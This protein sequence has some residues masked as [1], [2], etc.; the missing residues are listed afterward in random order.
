MVT[1]GIRVRENRVKGDLAQFRQYLGTVTR[2]MLKQ[3]ASLTARSALK[4]APP[5]VPTGGKGDTGA[6]GKTGERAIDKDVRAIFAEPGSTLASVFN[7][8]NRRGLFKDF[9]RWRSKPNTAGGSTL[10]SKIYSDDD[11]QRAF[12][13][14][15]N[16]FA[17]KPN[18]SK[19]VV[20]V[21]QMS[22]IHKQQRVKGRV[23][24][25]GRPDKETKRYPY[26]AKA[27]L[28]NKYVKLRSRAIGKLKSGWWEIIDRH[29]RG[30]VI[31][32]RV[33]DSGSKGLPKYITR[34]RGPGSL[35]ETKGGSSLRVRITNQIG[36][37]DGAG[38]RANTFSLVIRDRLAAISKRPYQQYA[39]RIVR[40][41][42]ANLPASS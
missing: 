8:E 29:G 22:T 41:W 16:L 40:N 10:I 33:V 42:N 20:N 13:K 6:A 24:R 15:S 1:F 12:Q 36:D 35:A 7:K 26:I 23:V 27:A 39:N 2:T 17:G 9:L 18:R 14:A 21:G 4:Y 11:V 31:F 30:L 37:S 28:I 3:E 32:G 34:H 19:T 5:L 25:E 38:L